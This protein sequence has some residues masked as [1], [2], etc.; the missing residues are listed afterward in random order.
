MKDFWGA[1]LLALMAL[2]G[3]IL[4]FAITIGSAY[5]EELATEASKALPK[6]DFVPTQATTNLY[7][8]C[9]RTDAYGVRKTLVGE[10]EIVVNICDK[11]YSF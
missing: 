3:A 1:L 11:K 9:D 8:E 7:Y 2:V 4:L 10:A 6:C 5:A